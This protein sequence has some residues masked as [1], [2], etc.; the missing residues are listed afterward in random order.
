MTLDDCKKAGREFR[1]ACRVPQRQ[2]DADSPALENLISAPDPVIPTGWTDPWFALDQ[3]GFSAQRFAQNFAHNPEK[4]ALGLPRKIHG[5]RDDRPMP[6]Q[7]PKA[8][9]PGE[10][11]GELHPKRGSRKEKDMRDASPVHYHL[12]KA[13]DGTLTIRVTAFPAK[14]LPDIETSRK[15]LSQL[16]EHLKADLEK[17]AKNLAPKGQQKAPSRAP[18]AARVPPA[19]S[20]GQALPKAGDLV[21]AVLVEDP[22]PKRTGRRFA[23]LVGS[24]RKGNIQNPGDV[25]ADKKIGDRVQLSVAICNLEQIQFRWPQPRRGEKPGKAKPRGGLGRR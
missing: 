20:A 22:D 25:P 16:L 1:E 17:R 14:Y 18:A 12:A 8:W 2:R 11:L 3:L 5:P 4:L 19:A 15:F 9:K 24:D 13:P 10:W 21:D 23:Q 7:E 6:N